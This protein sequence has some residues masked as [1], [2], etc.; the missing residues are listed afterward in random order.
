MR[1]LPRSAEISNSSTEFNDMGAIYMNLGPTPFHRGSVIQDNFFHHIAEEGRP[2][3]QGVYADDGSM[4]LTVHSNVFYKVNCGET[5]HAINSNGGAYINVTNNAFV[6]CGGP[7]EHTDGM[8]LSSQYEELVPKWEAAFAEAKANGMLPRL[9]ARYPEL[10]TFWTE[11]RREPKTN[12]FSNNLAYNPSVPR[13]SSF[14]YISRNFSARGFACQ[15][16]AMADIAS[17]HVWLARADPG[18]ASVA[19]MNFSLQASRVRPHIP[20]WREIDFA[21]IGLLG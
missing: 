14:D 4:G 10:A 2:I 17:E 8:M 19:R 16:C 6:D 12:T 9:I 11:D 21:A 5:C 18:F 7:F 15:D 1:P 3:I 13:G 20:G